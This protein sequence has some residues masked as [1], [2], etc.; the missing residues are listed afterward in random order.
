MIPIYLFWAA[1][2][3]EAEEQWI[4][5]AA[6]EIPEIFPGCAV[7]MPGGRARQ[8]IYFPEP[9]VILAGSFQEN[10]RRNASMILRR[11][12]SVGRQ[13][14]P[15]GIWIF[16]VAEDLSLPSLKLDWCF[17]AASVKNR[18]S[19][20]SLARFRGLPEEDLIYCVRRTLRH[21]LGHMFGMAADRKR[22]GTEE[23]HGPHCTNPGCS[24]RQTGTL[25]KLLATR[26]E[27]EGREDYFC[28]ACR[29]EY[30]AFRKRQQKKDM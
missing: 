21:E 2:V 14:D 26:K 7:R 8:R 16:F 6:A 23:H 10:G 29:A 28:P 4:R 20:Q 19:V 22:P 11:L 5:R 1:G 9:E 3:S 13:M 30:E 17:G 27:E 12:A 15:E 25:A 24:M 18:V